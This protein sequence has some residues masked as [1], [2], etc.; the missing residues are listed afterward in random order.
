[1]IHDQGS[2]G[3]QVGPNLTQALEVLG[4]GSSQSESPA[5]HDG[6]VEPGQVKLVHGLWVESDG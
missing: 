3:L 2:S 5:D 4:A 6:S 1:M